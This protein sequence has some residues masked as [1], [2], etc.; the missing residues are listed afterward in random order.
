MGAGGGNAFSDSDGGQIISEINVT[1]LVDI[2]LVLL[3]I[4]MVTASFIVTPAI[5]VDL[6]AA[7]SGEAGPGSSLVVTLTEDGKLYVNG[8]ES[9]ET[10]LSRFINAQLPTEPELQAIIAADENVSHGRVVRIIDLVKRSGIRKFAINV[11]P[12]S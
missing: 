1:P 12:G 10:A 11:D 2:I 3:I 9:G 4:F 5:P 6:P 7:A 8:E